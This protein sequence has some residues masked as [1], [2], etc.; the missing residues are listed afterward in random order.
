MKLLEPTNIGKLELRNRVIMEPMCMYSALNHDGVA[1][2]FHVAHYTA[3]AIGGVGLVIVE[4]TGIAPEGRI[5]D[6]CL[7]IYNDQQVNAL[8]KVVDSVHDNGA[9]IAIQI[10]HAGRKCGAVDGVDTIYGPSSIAYSDSYRTPIELDHQGIE[11]VI[12]EFVDAA[13]RADECGFDALEI[14]GAHGYLLSQFMSPYSN[15]RNDEYADGIL[16]T[17]RVVEA[18]RQVWPQN[19]PLLFRISA[20]D[21]EDNGLDVEKAIK[22]IKAIDTLIDV[23]N[24]S[25]GGITPTPPKSIYPGY[26]ISHAIAIRKATNL[27]VIGCG[28]LGEKDL[29]NYLIES[30]TVDFIGLARPLLKNPNWV[31]DLAHSRRLKEHIPFQYERGYK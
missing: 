7:G 1:T 26:Q 3:R 13:Q 6:A 24:V 23:V 21:F 12:Q 30:K 14:H 15:K 29:S 20:D 11:H 4:A 17:K 28:M 8:K 16:M 27:L 9:K 19:K 2:S 25:T 5:S 22:I 31:L 18:V 10:N